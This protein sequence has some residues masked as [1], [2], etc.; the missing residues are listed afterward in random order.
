MRAALACIMGVMI[1]SAWESST[2]RNFEIIV[3]PTIQSVSGYGKYVYDDYGLITPSVLGY[4]K[5]ELNF[6]AGATYGGLTAGVHS[7]QKS[8]FDWSVSLSYSGNLG[9]PGSW[10]G[11]RD[12]THPNGT[13][14]WL[15][16]Y[17]VSTP[18]MWAR[19]W[20]LEAQASIFKWRKLSLGLAGGFQSLRLKEDLFGA[21]GWQT[22]MV[23]RTDTVNINI[24]GYVGYYSVTWKVPYGGI[25]AEARP[26]DSWHTNLLLASGPAFVSDKDIHALRARVGTASGNG[27]GFIARLSSSYELGNQRSKVVPL[28]GFTAAWYSFSVKGSQS[29]TWWLDDPSTPLDET[30]NPVDGVPHEMT[31]QQFHLG[32]NLGVR[33]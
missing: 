31:T 1:C 18:K 14:G 30:K 25:C 10:M 33:F 22:G 26:V 23:D 24:D 5:S 28:V 3:T 11:D 2:A 17:T 19:S 7:R 6:P 4:V 9:D 21:Y 20:S 32:V 13:A 27:R 29:L 12:W 15:F 8:Q 16:S